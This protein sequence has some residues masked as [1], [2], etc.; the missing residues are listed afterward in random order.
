MFG[1]NIKQPV[2][3]TPSP[4]TSSVRT[5]SLCYVGSHRAAPSHFRGANIILNRFQLHQYLHVFTFPRS[6]LISIIDESDSI[7]TCRN[8]CSTHTV[9]AS[10]TAS[11]STRVDAAQ[12]PPRPPTSWN[13]SANFLTPPR[14][15]VADPPYY[16]SYL[17]M[18]RKEENYRPHFAQ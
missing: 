1:Q 16:C 9:Q 18:H 12:I 4:L 5:S 7:I 8:S 10:R 3:K 11:A 6:I 14:P 13:H 15:A 17:K 2:R